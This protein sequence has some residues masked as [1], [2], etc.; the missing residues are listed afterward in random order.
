MRTRSEIRE[1]VKSYIDSEVLEGLFDSKLTDK[2][3][4]V[5]GDI[6]DSISTMRLVS[7]LEQEF[8]ICLEGSDISVE[9]FD[10][11][12]MISDLVESKTPCPGQ[13][14]E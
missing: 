12:D 5:T 3:P 1:K 4:L 10:T 2:T 7:F 13:H 11:I 8:S 9:N 6:M 14:D